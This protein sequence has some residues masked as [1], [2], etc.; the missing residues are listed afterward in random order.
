M[1]ASDRKG[2]DCKNRGHGRGWS[3]YA[4]CECASED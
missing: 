3:T 1:P 4:D 2:E